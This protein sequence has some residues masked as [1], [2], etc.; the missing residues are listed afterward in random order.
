MKELADILLALDQ[1]ERGAVAALATV[2]RVQG[3]AYRSPGA[4]MLIGGDGRTTGGV[5][6]GCLERDVAQ[7]AGGVVMSG[8]PVLVQYDTS[9]DSDDGL[10]KGSG[11]S[12]GCGGTI[13]ILIEPLNTPAGADLFRWLA[14]S[15][16]S[17]RVIATVISKRDPAIPLGSRLML[18]ASGEPSG[19]FGAGDLAQAILAKCRSVLAADRPANERF[20]TSLGDLEVFFDLLQPPLELIIFG[21]GNDAMPLARFGRE[22]GWRVTV[23]DMG[24]SPPNP[25][26]VWTADQ[27]IRCH[28]D[29][30]F[31]QLRIG[32]NSAAV[33]MTHNHG[34]DGKLLHW[35]AER[36]LRYLGML[37]PRHRTDQLLG[38]LRPPVLRAPVGLDIGAETPEEVA[39]AIVA[40]IT[41]VLRGGSGGPLSAREGPIHL[42]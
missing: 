19:S 20:V 28:V 31:R 8:L 13:Q 4:K 1:L 39:L 38:E 18:A 9:Q 40:E 6:G 25:Q 14:G 23:V 36:P 29:E 27:V 26:R 30:V 10:S 11:Q 41:A 12:L 33:V 3:S 24:S 32:T 21:A 35:L 7:R 34:H 2:V 42:R 15:R 22:L 5:S 37:G 16:Q 17:R